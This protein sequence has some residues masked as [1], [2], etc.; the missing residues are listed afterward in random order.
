MAYY[1]IYAIT[2]TVQIISMHSQNKFQTYFGAHE[3]P[4]NNRTI[5]FLCR[6][7]IIHQPQL[8]SIFA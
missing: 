6:F 2:N 4:A 3:F 8:R 7:Y 5:Q 1:Q